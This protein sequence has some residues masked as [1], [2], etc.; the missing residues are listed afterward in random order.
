[1]ARSALSGSRLRH[2]LRADPPGD[3]L[4]KGR[5]E[6]GGG[7]HA[8]GAGAR[9]WSRRAGS[10]EESYSRESGGR[11]VPCRRS[12]PKTCH[13]GV[14][15]KEG[16]RWEV[17]GCGAVQSESRMQGHGDATSWERWSRG[18]WGRGGARMPA[19][20]RR[21]PEGE[22]AEAGEEEAEAGE[23]LSRRDRGCRRGG[24]A[25]ILSAA[26]CSPSGG[27]WKPVGP[28]CGLLSPGSGAF[29]SLQKIPEGCQRSFSREPLFAPSLPS[30]F[31]LAGGC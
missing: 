12:P 7:I 19:L 17:W 14:I 9:M 22:K 8:G 6:R 3:R 27:R 31:V 20:R 23:A 29:I 30:G 24:R 1:M 21:R 25:G 4:C 11:F 18:R 28:K 15:T 10:R 13:A 2:L 16:R 26:A 5:V